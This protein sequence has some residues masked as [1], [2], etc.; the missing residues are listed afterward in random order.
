MMSWPQTCSSPFLVLLLLHQQHAL[1]IDNRILIHSFTYVRTYRALST[2][3][4]G[5]PLGLPPRDSWALA[6]EGLGQLIFD[7]MPMRIWPQI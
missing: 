5:R 2:E 4:K 6:L 3:E 1:S 7:S